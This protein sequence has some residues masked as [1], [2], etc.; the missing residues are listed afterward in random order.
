MFGRSNHCKGVIYD[1]KQLYKNI[2]DNLPSF[3]LQ[4]NEK[5]KINNFL[6]SYIKIGE[7]RKLHKRYKC[8][9]RK[10]WYVVPSVYATQLA[11]L[12][13]VKWTTQ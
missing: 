11:L 2:D 5:T 7:K 3:F 6:K 10:P 1:E 9:I 8:R 13:I 12:R 4:I